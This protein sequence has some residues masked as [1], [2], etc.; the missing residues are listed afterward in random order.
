MAAKK[1]Y[2]MPGRSTWSHN[3]NAAMSYMLYS[4]S[5]DRDHGLPQLISRT[6]KFFTLA[7][8][9]IQPSVPERKR[10]EYKKKQDR[11]NSA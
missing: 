6:S 9:E 8:F 11:Q 3:L 5:E 1:I 2:T 10:I 7:H 4:E